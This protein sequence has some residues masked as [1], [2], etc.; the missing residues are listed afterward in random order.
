MV[1]HQTL[2]S[3]LETAL[4]SGASTDRAEALRYVS[5]LFEFGSEKFADSQI[6]EFDDVLMRLIADVETSARAM[7]ANRLAP[8]AKAPPTVIRRL[9]FDEAI[10][11]A[12]PVLT[13]SPRLDIRALV[14]N[15]KTKSQQHLFAISR[16]STLDPA[17]TDILLERGNRQV[18]HST[19]ANPGAKFSDAGF[20]TLIRRSEG[21]DSLTL[22]IGAR[23][24]VPRHHYLKLLAKASQA[25][26]AK[27]Q[28]ED[29][30]HAGD[31]RRAVADSAALIQARSAATSRDYTR[32]RAVV[33]PMRAAGRLGENEVEA[34]AKSGKFEETTVALALLCDLPVVVIERAMVL[35]RAE[36]ILIMARAAGL[37]W[38]SA[39]TILQL[40]AGSAGISTHELEQGLAS[41]ARLKLKTAQEIVRFQR[42]RAAE[43]PQLH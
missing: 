22:C 28:A 21:D 12:G 5:D 27:L 43:N 42:K 6:A 20:I 29:P 32:A 18:I 2:I 10:E 41:Y 30:L 26:R 11:V 25:V 35:D 23:P 39:K 17:V 31:V 33:G 15:A 34:F 9:A 1:P 7:L 38:R 37:T 3:T 19:A 16:R 36:T 4:K 14:E 8:M 13:Q 40:R 24:D